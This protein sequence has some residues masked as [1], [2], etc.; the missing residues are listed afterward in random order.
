MV[1][2]TWFEKSVKQDLRTSKTDN[3]KED[4]PKSK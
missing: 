2:S 1:Y 3:L 4:I